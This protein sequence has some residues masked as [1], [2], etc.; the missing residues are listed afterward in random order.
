[1]RG[2]DKKSYPLIADGSISFDDT[3]LELS[4]D[5]KELVCLSANGTRRWSKRAP[6]PADW[7]RLHGTVND[8]RGHG[9]FMWFD[10]CSPAEIN[11]AFAPGGPDV[12]L[13]YD[14]DN[15]ELTRIRE[16]R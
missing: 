15:G 3:R 16:T 13:T 14:P 8:P 12:L 6:T 11:I 9:S 7:M 4:P 10:S 1:M 2:D 5:N